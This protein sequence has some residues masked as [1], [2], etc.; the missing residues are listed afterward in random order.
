[1]SVTRLAMDEQR[2]CWRLI[3]GSQ[4]CLLLQ[5][6]YLPLDGRK[7]EGRLLNMCTWMH[8]EGHCYISCRNVQLNKW[9][10]L[11]FQEE[12]AIVTHQAHETT[13]CVHSTLALRNN[14]ACT[15]LSCASACKVWV[16]LPWMY[17]HMSACTLI[18]LYYSTNVHTFHSQGWIAVLN[19]EQITSMCVCKTQKHTTFRGAWMPSTVS[20]QL[21][22]PD[23]WM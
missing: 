2:A 10:K 7:E 17:A 15:M 16:P 5:P 11:P 1:M 19:W 12:A 14:C 18:A 6:V 23:E 13:F 22:Q 20:S 4:S 9:I 8:A 21:S 3:K